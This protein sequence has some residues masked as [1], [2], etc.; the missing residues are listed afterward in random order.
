MNVT[1]PG[2]R[3]ARLA[4]GAATPLTAVGAIDPGVD[5]DHAA[6]MMV[7][8]FPAVA[9]ATHGELANTIAIDHPWYGYAEVNWADEKGG[10]CEGVYLYPQP[11]ANNQFPNQPDIGA[12]VQAI[13]GSKPHHYDGDHLKGDYSDEWE[14]PGGGSVRV[15]GHLVHVTTGGHFSK[16]TPRPEWQ[17]LFDGMDACGRKR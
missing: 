8:A 15:Y 1:D 16:K 2:R 3:V 5:V 12:C 14:L 6:A 9:T 13:V 17:K 4:R 7:A 10:T 11:G